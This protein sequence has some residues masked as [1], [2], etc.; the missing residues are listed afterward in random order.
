MKAG[1][2]CPFLALMAKKRGAKK[3]RERMIQVKIRDIGVIPLSVS[4]YLLKAG[5]VSCF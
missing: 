2:S 1:D 3:V 4:L 5:A